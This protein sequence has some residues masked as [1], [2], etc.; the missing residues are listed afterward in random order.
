MRTNL[1]TFLATLVI[2]ALSLFIT[3]QV[4]EMIDPPM[5][6]GHKIMPLKIVFKSV[7]ISCILTLIFFIFFRKQIKKNK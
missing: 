6:D 4:L 5:I 7:I 1:I 3:Y 2:L